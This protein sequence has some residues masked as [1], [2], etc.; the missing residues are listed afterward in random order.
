MKRWIIAGVASLIVVTITFIFWHVGHSA[1]PAVMVRK[2]IRGTGDQEQLVMRLNMAR[3]DTLAP[4]LDA[5]DAEDLSVKTRCLFLELLLKRYLRLAD[6]RIP[7]AIEQALNHS[8][9]AVRLSVTRNVAVYGDDKLRLLLIDRVADAIPDV[10]SEAALVLAAGWRDNPISREWGLMDETD[11]KRLMSH[12]KAQLAEEKDAERQYQLRSVIG[13]HIATLTMDADNALSSADLTRAG[14]LLRQAFELDPGS[15]R[16]QVRHVRH[17]LTTG[18]REAAIQKAE[19]YGALMR[20]PR[21]DVVPELDGDPT[22]PTWD[23]AFSQDKFYLA[24][25]LWTGKETEGRTKVMIGHRDG[26]VYVAMLGYEDDLGAIVREHTG[27]D[28]DT[29]RDDSVEFFFDPDNSE[30]NVYQFVVNANGAVF[31]A[32]QLRR[33]VNAEC[34]CAAAVF[35]DRGYWA[36]EFAVKA[37]DLENRKITSESIWG[38]NLMRARIG[39]ASEQCAQWPTFGTSLN[40]QYNPI[41]I[42]E[43]APTGNAAE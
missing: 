10:R 31:D 29:W 1:H 20:I 8:D 24:G 26:T 21:L 19:E 39:P 35:E 30:K 9:D 17:L 3:G 25:S 16:A 40:F 27:R 41:A 5:L 14:E 18:D 4:M 34:E 13:R 23:K 43:D 2:L 11:V 7:A 32:Y 38:M 33:E 22:D 42:F 28:S 37:A 15:M 6:D 36:V 12:C